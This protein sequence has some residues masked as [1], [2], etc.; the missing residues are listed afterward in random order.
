MLLGVQILKDV[1]SVNSFED[2]PVA[3][4]TAGDTNTVY[5]QLMDLTQ[6]IRYIPATGATLSCV[7]ENLDLNK[8]ITRFAAQPF[9]ADD[10][11]IWSLQFLPS[12]KLQGTANLRITLTEGSVIHHGIAKC[13]FRI[14]PNQALDFAG[15]GYNIDP[16][17]F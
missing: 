4:W 9:S 3:E 17:A 16:N 15:T 12:D 14:Q 1:Q 6:G 8:Q 11:S 2:V 13:V 7:A 5:F 10:R